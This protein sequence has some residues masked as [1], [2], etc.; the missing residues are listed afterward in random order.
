MVKM[1]GL[2]LGLSILFGKEDNFSMSL[3]VIL[4]F[5]GRFNAGV[6]VISTRLFSTTVNAKTLLRR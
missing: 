5:S 3:L 4:A 1:R 6:E 2:P